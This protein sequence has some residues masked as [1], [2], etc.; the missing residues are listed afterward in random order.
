MYSYVHFIKCV[1]LSRLLHVCMHMMTYFAA[2]WKAVYK[3]I[4]PAP[5]NLFSFFIQH[6]LKSFVKKI[7]FTVSRAVRR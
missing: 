6:F 2:M 4:N 5:C 7:I 3:E 1:I